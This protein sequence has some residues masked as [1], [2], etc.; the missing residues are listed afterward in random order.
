MKSPYRQKK[1]N[2]KHKDEHRAIM[3]NHVGRELD[4][5]ELVHHKDEDRCNNRIENLKIVSP[6]EHSVIHNQKYPLI[7]ACEICGLI[8]VPKPHKRGGRQPTCSIKCGRELQSRKIRK[9]NG[10][11]SMYRKDAFKSEKIRAAYL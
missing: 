5:F 8:F 3:E 11:R 1:I 2:G 7:W 6:K 10:K 4:R 9:A